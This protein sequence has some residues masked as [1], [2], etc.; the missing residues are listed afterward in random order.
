[1]GPRVDYFWVLV[2][3][4]IALYSCS[5]H[6]DCITGG[7]SWVNTEC[8]QQDFS[9]EKTFSQELEDESSN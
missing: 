3:F 9:K 6:R 2:L 5:Y 8:V 7:G 4:F 1:M